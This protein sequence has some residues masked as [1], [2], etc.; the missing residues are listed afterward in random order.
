MAAASSLSEPKPESE[1][2]HFLAFSVSRLVSSVVGWLE[3]RKGGC[4]VRGPPWP[5]PR[6]GGSLKLKMRVWA[7]GVGGLMGVA[8]GP[9]SEVGMYRVIL[10][11][12]RAWVGSLFA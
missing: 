7:A 3:E 1:R 2:A 6:L 5:G 11:T 4:E 8:A 9:S 12:G 10:E